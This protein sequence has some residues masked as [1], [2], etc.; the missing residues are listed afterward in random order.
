MR[1][2]HFLKLALPTNT[3]L[4]AAFLSAITMVK[5]DF[6]LPGDMRA[7]VGQYLPEMQKRIQPHMLEQ[8]GMVVNR[9]IQAAPEVN[10]SKWGNAVDATAHRVGF[11]I[12]GDLE[13]AARMVSVEPVVVGGP[14]VKDKVKELV[15]YSISEDYFKVRNH[16]GTT[17]G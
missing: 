1:P 4:K 15:V 9:F 12:S 5:R 10:L 17:I 6:P 3:E 14:Q 2:D 7:A 8:L 13:V 11:I 16:L